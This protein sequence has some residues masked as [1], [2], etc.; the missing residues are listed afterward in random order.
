LTAEQVATVYETMDRG[1]PKVVAQMENHGIKVDRAE[2]SR[3]SAM[4]AQKMAGLEDEA[5]E[6][7]GDKFNIGSPK[8]IGEILFDKMGL[9][10]GKKTKTGAWKTGFD[11]LETLADEGEEDVFIQVFLWLQ[12]RRGVCLH[13]T[14]TFKIFPFVQKKAVKY[15]MLLLQKKA[16]FW[17]R[18]IILKLSFVFWLMWR[19]STL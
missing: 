10:G 12:Q 9:E 3:L 17:S 16:M 5:Y 15:A 2:L 6:L 18:Q 14:L 13:L 19:N 1:L 4:F 11:V 7:A 8:Q